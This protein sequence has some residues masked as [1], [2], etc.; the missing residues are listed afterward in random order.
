MVLPYSDEDLD[1]L[2]V[3]GRGL[4]P[5]LG[6]PIEEGP[7]GEDELRLTHFRLTMRAERSL[8]LEGKDSP[9]L[10]PWRMLGTAAIRDPK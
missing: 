10:E 1:A 9:T 3:F 5:R 4:L 2:A 6:R 8:A 7:S